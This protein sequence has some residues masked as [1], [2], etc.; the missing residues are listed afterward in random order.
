MKKISSGSTFLIKKIFP[1]FWFG[2]LIIF[3]VTAALSGAAESSLS[4]VIIPVVWL[5]LASS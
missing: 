5:S 4:F 2:F 1:A 3:V